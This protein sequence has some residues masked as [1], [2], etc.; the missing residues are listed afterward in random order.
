MRASHPKTG[1][2]SSFPG[3]E[4]GL[5]TEGLQCVRVVAWGE[6]GVSYYGFRKQ[7]SEAVLETQLLLQESLRPYPQLETRDKTGTE[8]IQKKRL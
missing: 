1:K 6:N 2:D 3:L 5:G 4:V 7:G 8:T